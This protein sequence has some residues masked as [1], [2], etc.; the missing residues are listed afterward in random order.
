MRRLAVISDIHGNLHA[1]QAVLARIDAIGV[2]A[3][4]CLGDVV[5]YGPNPG[6]CIDLIRAR[7]A[8]TVRGNHDEAVLQT[9]QCFDFNA[10]ARAAIFWTRSVLSS[11]QKQWLH[12]IP[13]SHSW[14]PGLVCV[15]DSPA[16]DEVSYLHNPAD[17]ARAFGRTDAAV[18]LV[19]HTH[20]PMAFET[21]SLCPQEHLRPGDVESMV[22]RDKVSVV[23]DPG[24]RYILNPGSVG[25]PRDADSRA[26]FAILDV[27]EM[28]FSL[29]REHY[30]IAGAQLAMRRA[31]LPMVLAERLS[32]GA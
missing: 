24:C 14:S 4:L 11:D 5:G 23:L 25:Q 9:S 8:A 20:I 12:E 26:S 22:L 3:I 13:M 29:Y 1:L 31:G 2:D 17:A 30:D 18:T 15:H 19:G 21:Q 27:A 16:P 28:T 32:I 10:P 7:C 6:A